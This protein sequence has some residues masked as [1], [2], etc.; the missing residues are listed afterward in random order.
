MNSMVT[1]INQFSSLKNHLKAS[2]LIMVV[3]AIILA[4]TPKFATATPNDSLVSSSAPKFLTVDEAFVPTMT[5]DGATVTLNFKIAP[6]YYLYQEIMALDVENAELLSIDIP[7]GSPHQDEYMGDTHIFTQNVTLKATLKSTNFFPKIKVTFQGCTTG[8]CYPP[9]TKS[10]NLTRVLTS[11]AQ[12]TTV[13]DQADSAPLATTPT[14]APTTDS[15]QNKNLVSNSST[16][17]SATDKAY[18]LLKTHGP[19]L[20]LLSF[21]GF[22]FLLSLTPCMFP[23][24]PIWSAIILGKKEKTLKTTILFSFLYTQGLALTYMGVGFV[25]AS[26]GAKFHAFMQQPWVLITMSVLFVLLALSC[27][28]AFSFTLPM[29][30]QNKLNNASTKLKGGSYAGVFF[31]GAL[32]A[33]IAS[34]CT[35]APLA[36]AL[37]YI[38][39]EGN[40][41]T[42]GLSL[43][44]L[45]IGMSV[46]LFIIAFA[47]HKFLPKSG[48]WMTTVRIMCGF[49]MLIVPLVLLENMLDP[50][51]VRCAW[52][53]LIGLTSCCL[54]FRILPAPK[55]QTTCACQGFCQSKAS[56]KTKVTSSPNKLKAL[57]HLRPILVAAVIAITITLCLIQNSS[58]TEHGIAH[59]PQIQTLEE[60]ATI[61]P[62]TNTVAFI[63]LDFRA[64]WCRECIHMEQTT[65]SDPR[66]QKALAQGLVYQ[67]DVTSPNSPAQEIMRKYNLSGVPAIVIF[68]N[69]QVP[70]ILNGY[71]GA[72][73]LLPY[74][75]NN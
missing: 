36:G 45:A 39:Q 65:F 57:L 35:T 26:A 18:S 73:E 46:P 75:K 30:L 17:N 59:Y 24:Y 74:L 23:M 41:L 37:L 6:K 21:F 22:G 51:V 53:L 14:T 2:F 33:I 47:G 66:V 5:Q 15:L 64:D 43:Y 68:R 4:L 34:P 48:N 70:K 11:N 32:S 27:F 29:A 67:A 54:I 50:L 19:L 20:A 61:T 25:I 16:P 63:M 44:I 40:I 52:I 56:L 69:N 49:L 28:G 62:K 1:A 31:M 42:G 12:A 13:A 58:R 9:T 72:D 60:L 55:N 71:I 7:Q 38:A 8:L 3:G 10:F